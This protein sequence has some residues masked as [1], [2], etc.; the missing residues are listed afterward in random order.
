MARCLI[1]EIVGSPPL[2]EPRRYHVIDP[3]IQFDPFSPKPVLGRLPQPL[4][5]QLVLYLPLLVNQA[6]N[7]SASSVG[8]QQ[9]RL[10]REE[11]NH[12]KD[13]C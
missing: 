5:L 3:G 7:L 11:L 12:S 8:Y 10:G 4:N 1:L 6:V 2:P 13:V 9:C